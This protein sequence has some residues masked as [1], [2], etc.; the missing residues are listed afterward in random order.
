[1][2]L[3]RR[4]Y[5]ERVMRLAEELTSIAGAVDIAVLSFDEDSKD[6]A[7]SCA[8]R[9]IEIKNELKKVEVEV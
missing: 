5:K 4:A 8:G 3:T 6:I 2:T 9:L 1:M 7:E